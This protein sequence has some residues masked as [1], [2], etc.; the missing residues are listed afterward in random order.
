MN[1]FFDP[2]TLDFFKNLLTRPETKLALGGLV[3]LIVLI[4][5]FFIVRNIFRRREEQRS[6]FDKKILLVTVPKNEE[7]DDERK[8]LE[9]LLQP[10][11]KLFDNLGGRAI[12]SGLKTS[13]LKRQDHFSLEIVSGK[14]G[15]ISF[16]IAVPK[17]DKRFFEQQIHAQYP[18]ARITEVEDYNVFSANSKTAGAFLKLQ[19]N[20]A[21]P[22]KT[23]NDF[24]KDPL[25]AIVNSLSKIDPDDAAVIQFI[26]RPASPGWQKKGVKAAKKI[27][28][29]GISVKKALNSS[30]FFKTINELFSGT[31]K[32]EDNIK[33]SSLSPMEQEVVKS[34]EKKS[35]KTGLEVNVRIIV[36][37]NNQ[38]KANNYLNDITDSFAQYRG[39]EYLNGFQL[40]K[41]KKTQLLMNDFIY[42]SFNKNQKIILNTE[43][44]VS[45]F[46]IP[47]PGL[48]TPNVQWAIA[49][50]LP[51]PA[52]APSQEGT[53]I[54]KN[55]FRGEEKEVRIKKAD[56]R[57][58]F[59]VIGKTGTG[60][61]YLLTRMLIEDIK[62]GEGGCFIDPHGDAIDT[63]LKHIPEERKD[64]VIYFN[65]ADNKNA[66]GL[67]LLEYDS[68]HPEQ[69]T[70]AVNEMINIM[71]K[72]YDLDKTGGPMFE[73]YMRNAMLLIME[74]PE[75]GSTL[76]EIPRVLADAD[77]RHYKLDRCQNSVVKDFWVTQAEKAGGEA[78]LSNIT[79]YITS[80]LN[81]F[82]SN[83]IMRPIIGQ[84]KSAFDFREVMD[85]QKIL[86][87]NLSKGR[88]GEKN[89]HLLGLIIIGKILMA[90]LSRTDTPEEQRK[91]FYLYMDE[92]QNFITESIST[93]LAEA[94]KYRLCLHMAHQYIDQ[95]V[96]NQD[97]SIKDAVFG[98][99]GTIGAF[100]VGREDAEFLSK[101]F[102][103][104]VT[105]YDLTNIEKYN[106]YFKLLVDNQST[107]PFNVQTIVLPNGDPQ[108][109]E[110][111]KKLS[112]KKYGIPRQ[113]AEEDIKKRMKLARGEK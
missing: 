92:F 23:Y 89:A 81:Q 69:K 39:H 11:E 60:K 54:A 20:S 7:E 44:L 78:S 6:A 42:R 19:E 62:N 38:I 56:R 88:L 34:L 31:A 53:V 77:F 43:E 18:H 47:L 74:D 14:E 87:I 93:I 63:I 95:L 105:P 64:D 94:R 48:E 33:P 8:P 28:E 5:V 82:V 22:I 75:S 101:E 91:D 41:K 37:A 26:V 106:A 55:L 17:E 76:M 84:Q 27:Q 98:T 2:L 79:P 32:K 72:L 12:E 100:K 49:K 103:D 107:R 80:K 67:N 97:E 104:P 58:H 65:P 66:M 86:L 99:V 50:T 83:D 96:R 73:Q 9:D 24:K 1:Q 112:E 90:S 59:Y 108:R 21:L 102:G 13:F 46:H 68:Q 36:S 45:L 3:V 15:I 109:S 30:K 29:E 10:A 110:E 71:D 40:K 85:N 113:K 70:F 25:N 4:V 111:V 61:T 57:R 52:E 51:L 35:S 16:Y